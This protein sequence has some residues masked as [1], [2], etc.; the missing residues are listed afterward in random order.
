MEPVAV[1]RQDRIK[2]K[3]ERDIAQ[4]RLAPSIILH[5]LPGLGKERMAFYLAQRILCDNPRVEACGECLSCR[6]VTRLLHPDVQWIFPKPGSVKDSELEK[7]VRRKSEEEFFIPTFEKTSSHAIDDIRQL[8]TISGKCPYEGRYKVFIVTGADRMT[9]EAANAFLKLLE[10]P[11]D[12]TVIVMTTSRLYALL[13]TIRSRCEEI[14]FSPLPM[15]ELRDALTGMLDIPF[16]QADQLSRNSEGSLGRAVW[17]H[18]DAGKDGFDDA[19]QILR[20]AWEGSESDRL[21]YAVKG[22]LKGDRERIRAALDVLISLLRDLIASSFD[23]GKDQLINVSRSDLIE[24]HGDVSVEG[25][26]H[27]MKRVDELRNLLDRNT[28]TSILLWQLLHSLA[29]Q[30]RTGQP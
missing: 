7:V 23:L 9:V 14:R 5:G 22:S 25:V 3:F 15:S 27:S 8:R 1:Y 20:L 28:N 10:E 6:K 30:I 13:P 17:M 29:S 21:A 19:W 11:P 26:I 24:A 2:E 4:E 12:D 16:D 18:R